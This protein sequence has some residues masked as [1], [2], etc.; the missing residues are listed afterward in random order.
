MSK[1]NKNQDSL[2]EENVQEEV[3]VEN[4]DSVE[5]TTAE[6]EYIL[7]A[8]REQQEI[9]AKEKAKK[10]KKAQE[11]A[12]KKAASRPIDRASLLFRGRLRVKER[13]GFERRVVNLDG[14]SFHDKLAKGFVPVQSDNL[15][16]Y[17]AKG[18]GKL[19]TADVRV[20]GPNKKA[21]VM[22]R[23]MEIKEAYDR[24]R[25]ERLALTQ[26]ELNKGSKDGLGEG[27]MSRR[28]REY[29]HNL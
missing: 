21:I 17:A 1:K 2:I 26:K 28:S 13:P 24:Q 7:K 3:T 15:N 11:E 19:S 9:D 27:N 10:E 18:E 22:E 20:V 25:E 16:P 23:P 29:R 8:I 4:G 6:Q 5:L 12:K 14:M